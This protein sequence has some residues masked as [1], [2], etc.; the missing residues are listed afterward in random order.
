M[1]SGAERSRDGTLVRIRAVFEESPV[2]VEHRFYRGASA[3]MR[4]LFEGYEDF[5]NHVKLQSRPGD[6]FL[7]W[8]YDELC[9]DDNK[10]EDAKL[11]DLQG[12][13]PKHG[14]Y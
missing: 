14:P 13:V 1:G 3:P 6:H 12:R 7:I 2:I 4:L 5:L 11:P 8:R 10:V 9:R